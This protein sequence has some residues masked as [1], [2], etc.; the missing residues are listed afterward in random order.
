MP[1]RDISVKPFKFVFLPLGPEFTKKDNDT[2]RWFKLQPSKTQRFREYRS[3]ELEVP[4]PS[5]TYSYIIS[6]RSGYSS[7]FGSKDAM[8]LAQERVTGVGS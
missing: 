4:E 3:Y 2:F 8:D 1:F 6:A 5:K 7:V